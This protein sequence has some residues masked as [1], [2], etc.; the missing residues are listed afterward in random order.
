[1]RSKVGEQAPV[2]KNSI[3]IPA[4]EKKTIKK[5]TKRK[6]IESIQ[7][8]IEKPEKSAA[9]SLGIENLKVELAEKNDR[10]CCN[11]LK[12]FNENNDDFRLK[13]F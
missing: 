8:Q 11:R 10:F 7:K 5:R 4:T 6:S 13:T 9:A 2:P 1:M 3:C 12:L